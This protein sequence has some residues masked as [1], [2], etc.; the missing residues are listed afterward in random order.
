[1]NVLTPKVVSASVCT[2]NYGN[3]VTESDQLL[4]PKMNRLDQHQSKMEIRG[5][6]GSKSVLTLDHTEND[7][8]FEKEHRKGSH[9]NDRL[10]TSKC[11]PQI[12]SSSGQ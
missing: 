7:S 8:K 12:V 3:F 9:C 4:C 1:M 2:R 6:I 10:D 5:V 11:F